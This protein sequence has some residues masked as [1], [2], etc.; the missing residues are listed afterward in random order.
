MRRTLKPLLYVA[1][2]LLIPLLLWVFCRSLGARSDG[3]T[4][5]KAEQAVRRA[6]VQ[7]YAL[8]GFYPT[9]LSYLQEHYGVAAET[10]SYWVGYI[11]IAD[12]LM[13]DITILPRN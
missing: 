7:C 2:T 3:E 9:E 12:N 1:I 13:P 6:A 4:L 10:Q 5:Q 11:Y 8:E